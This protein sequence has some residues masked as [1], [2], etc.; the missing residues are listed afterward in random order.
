MNILV[1]GNGFD[2]AHGLPTKYENF[3]NFV[4][5]FENFNTSAVKDEDDINNYITNLKNNNL[6]LFNEIDSLT[7][8]NI[9]LD[10]FDS[11]FESRKNEGK[12]GWIDFEGEISDIIQTLDSARHTLNEQF[13]NGESHAHMEQWQLNKLLPFFNKDGKIYNKEDCSYIN[14]AIGLRKEQALNDLNRMTRCLE[15]YLCDFISFNKCA[16]LKDIAQLSI[17]KVLSFNYTDTYRKIYCKNPILEM[18]CDFIHGK[19]ELEHDIESCSLVLGID[20]YLTNESMNND[21]EFIQFKKFYQRIYKGTGSRYID[22]LE[23]RREAINKTSKLSPLELTIIF[24]GH[25]LDVTDGDILRKLILEEG[26]RTI[27]FYHDKKALG[28]QISNLV[29]VIGEEELIKRTGGNRRTILFQKTS[30]ETL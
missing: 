14:T 5:R 24:Y 16:P 9:W 17:N 11:I 21:N 30:T 29:K 4:K 8:E 23:K 26:A 13:K 25:S 7:K 10:Y 20:E 15:I 27:I 2:I 3:L 12:D 28:N 6:I 19:A 18:E 1:L 22:W